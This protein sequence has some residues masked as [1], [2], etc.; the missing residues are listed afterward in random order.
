MNHNNSEGEAMYQ[1]LS[2]FARNL[3]DLARKEKPD[4]VIGR[5]DEIRAR[6]NLYSGTGNAA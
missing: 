4:P 1:S 3:S 6:I 2:R 5:D